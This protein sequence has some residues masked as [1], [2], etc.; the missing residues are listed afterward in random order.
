MDGYA[1]VFSS[2]PRL[3]SS[4]LCRLYLD[5][6][7]HVYT[8]KDVVMSTNG[9]WL[10]LHTDRPDDYEVR[11]PRACPRIIDVTYGR[12]VAR[13]V[14][15]FVHTLPKHSTAVYLMDWRGIEGEW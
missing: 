15:C 8:D 3:S 6:G 10:M 1:T 2:I 14:D 12:T 7:V 4:L 13:N 11:L 5:S 9:T